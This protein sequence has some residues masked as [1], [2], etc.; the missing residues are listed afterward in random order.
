MGRPQNPE[1][2]PKKWKTVT[3][4]EQVESILIPWSIEHFAQAETTPLA[5]EVWRQRLDIHEPN[6][7]IKEIIDGKFTVPLTEPIECIQFIKASKRPPE[8]T[9]EIKS[10]MT[11]KKCLQFFKTVTEK[12][13]SS[14]RGRH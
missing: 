7:K 12:K 14:P 4:R 1:K 11:F 8:V 10:Q 2:K 6:N 13:T 3:K 5:K 9:E